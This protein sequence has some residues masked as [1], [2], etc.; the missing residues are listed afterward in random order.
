MTLSLRAYARHRG[1]TL[2]AVQKAVADGR[3]TVDRDEKN[4]IKVDPKKAD[5]Q[6]ARN[7]QGAKDRTK[8]PAHTSIEGPS[9]AESRAVREEYQAKIAKL[10]FEEMSGKLVDAEEVKKA[11]TSI[12][13]ITKTRLLSV[14][15]KAKSKIPHLTLDDIATLEELIREALSEVATNAGD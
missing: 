2:Q 8:A 5:A 7:T 10:T 9:Y 6:W 13:A 14:P 3:I 4:R 1:V 12:I 15:S 11:W